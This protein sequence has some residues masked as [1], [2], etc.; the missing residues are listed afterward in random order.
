MPDLVKAWFLI[1]AGF[2]T[3]LSQVYGQIPCSSFCVDSIG[4]DTTGQNKLL[5]SLQFQGSPNSFI[6]Y[7]W[8]PA[9]MNEQGDTIARGQMEF[10]G[11]FGNSKQVYSA[12]TNLQVL[13]DNPVI[14]LLFKYDTLQCLLS[15]PCTQVSVE[16]I[17]ITLFPVVYP[18]PFQDVIQ[19]ENLPPG[20]SYRI[21][22][23]GGRMISEG[24]INEKTGQLNLY[25]LLPGLYWINV[26]DS[27]RKLLLKQ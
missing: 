21:F 9:V 16:P 2:A 3:T 10:F 24:R 27:F 5:I 26:G 8:F 6:N 22:N 20:T 18:N 19:Y 15:Y 7:P 11:Q 14:S 23:S 17:E 12:A 1:L 13:P 4:L 25:D